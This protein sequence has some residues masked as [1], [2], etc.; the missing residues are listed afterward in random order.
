[1]GFLACV[2]GMLAEK[3]IPILVFSSYSTD[4]IL[5]RDEHLERVLELLREQGVAVEER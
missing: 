4:H 1:M 3:R 2:A 5:V